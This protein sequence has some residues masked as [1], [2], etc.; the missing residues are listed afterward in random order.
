MCQ[1][2]V[3]VEV[4]RK[5]P[6]APEPIEH[7]FCN[8]GKK[9]LA[10]NFDCNFDCNVDCF[11]NNSK[12]AKKLANGI[13]PN[14]SITAL[15]CCARQHACQTETRLSLTRDSLSSA[16]QSAYILT[17]PS[18]EIASY[19]MIDDNWGLILVCV[20]AVHLKQ[21]WHGRTV[22]ALLACTWTMGVKMNVQTH[23]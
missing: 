19:V 1:Q 15:S 10:D 8:Q 5:D 23:S 22:T 4:R 2:I 16:G 18:G 3:G 14:F 13:S 11:G 17:L 9:P 7:W 21:I 6:E 12:P 20:I